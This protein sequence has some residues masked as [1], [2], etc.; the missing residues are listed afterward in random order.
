MTRSDSIMSTRRLPPSS[1]WPCIRSVIMFIQLGSE[2][3]KIKVPSKNKSSTR[4][5]VSVLKHNPN[6][7]KFE[8]NAYLTFPYVLYA[9]IPLIGVIM[10]ICALYVFL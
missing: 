3:A 4:I 8:K 5:T 10:G 2:D 9:C 6:T 7:R 1:K